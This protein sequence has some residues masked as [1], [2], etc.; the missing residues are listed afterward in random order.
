MRFKPETPYILSHSPVTSAAERHNGWHEFVG[1]TSTCAAITCNPNFNASALVTKLP[2][3]VDV[4]AHGVVPRIAP[5]HL[6]GGS[7]GPSLRITH[8]PIPIPFLPTHSA[9]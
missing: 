9:S 8:F 6:R 4:I 1:A 5:S 3:L 2:N 7:I